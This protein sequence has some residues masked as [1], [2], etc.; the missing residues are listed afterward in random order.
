MQKIKA[1]KT[2]K[3]FKKAFSLHKPPCGL[4]S[5]T[6]KNNFSPPKISK[7]QKS[8]DHASKIIFERGFL[9]KD[10]SGHLIKIL[11]FQTSKR[12][13]NIIYIYIYI[14]RKLTTRNSN[15]LSDIDFY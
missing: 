5:W 15:F 11:N 8:I 1:F 3:H 2:G 12:K 7:I 9:I 13:N 6:S 10:I 4:S 14:Y